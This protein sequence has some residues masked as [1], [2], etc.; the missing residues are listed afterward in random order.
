MQRFYCQVCRS[1]KR[2]RR[3]PVP[4]RD[5]EGFPVM[6]CRWH[7]SGMTHQEFI[8]S[9]QTPKGTRLPQPKK[10]KHHRSSRPVRRDLFAEAV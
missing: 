8:R 9:E 3:L 4:I 10:V 6:Q 5:N 7:E 1:P 2:V